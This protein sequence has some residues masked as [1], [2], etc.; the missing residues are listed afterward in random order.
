MRHL[1]WALVLGLLVTVPVS[2]QDGAETPQIDDLLGTAQQDGG[3]SF[4][5]EFEISAEL[6]AE[7]V[8]IGE[9]AY[10][11]IH[12]TLPMGHHISSQNPKANAPTKI[13]V[14]TLTG[15]EPIDDGFTPTETPDAHEDEFVGYVEYF[16]DKATW[17]RRY[18]ILDPSNAT[19]I[20]TLNG[21]YC[22][23][24]PGGQCTPVDNAE[25]EAKLDATL[26]QPQSVFNIQVTPTRGK[27]NKPDPVSLEFDLPEGAKVGDEITLR[28]TMILDEGW[29]AFS[30]DQNP[31]N[32]GLPIVLGVSGLAGLEAIDEDFAVDQT[33]EEV[34]PFD[35]GTIQLQLHDTV[36]WTQR[37]RVTDPVY[38]VRG[39]I[40]YQ[41]CRDNCLAPRDVE[42]HL[43]SLITT[44]AS[45]TPSRAASPDEPANLTMGLLFAFL[46]G[47][48]LNVMPCVLPVLSIKMLSFA[49]Q[50]GESRGRVLQLNLSYAVGVISVFLLLAGLA[51]AAGYG[52]GELFQQ[53]EFN[54]VMTVIIFVMA[55]SL[56]GVFEIPIPGLGGG[57]GFTEKE[58]PTGAFLTGILAT[59]LATPCSGPFLGP[60]LGWSIKQQAFETF[61]IWGVMGFGMAFPYVLV[62][63]FPAAIRFLPKPGMWMVRF[64]EICGFALLATV[65]YFVTLLEERYVVPLLIML[66]G[67]AVSLWMI[68]KLYQHNSPPKTKWRVRG[69]ALTSIAVVGSFSYWMSIEGLKLPWQPFTEQ[70][71]KSLMAEKKTIMV[72][73]SAEWCQTCKWNELYA[74][75]TEETLAVIEEHGIIPVYA[76]YTHRSPEIKKWLD[77]FD[78][79]SIPLTV[80]VP[81]GDLKRA[82]I[83]RDTFSKK[84]LLEALK[85][86]AN[87]NVAMPW[88]APSPATAKQF[89]D[90][91]ATALIHF[92]ADYDQST[93]LNRRT[94]ID[95]P[96]T[97]RFVEEH[98]I[99][100]LRIDCTDRTPECEEWTERFGGF[101][102]AM[103]MTVVVPKGDLDRATVLRDTFCKEE[104]LRVLRVAVTEET[105]LV[106]T[107]ARRDGDR[108][109]SVAWSD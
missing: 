30:R 12:V 61:L 50:A 25:F 24:G 16:H 63:M 90:D 35:D 78:S 47:L 95:V 93:E 67:I 38:A 99:I 104:L 4:G 73:F 87:A 80:I 3:F 77:H 66:L 37:Y 40:T 68:G 32:L 20:G 26:E 81:Q 18:K 65:I 31:D 69:M 108:V 21:L 106:R 13:G 28:V 54:L 41:V 55:L 59:V 49:K 86:A 5:G 91:K 6:V 94:A 10:L 89:V 51:I 2:A 23:S 101:W 19:A 17:V 8:A 53:A 11:K 71:F 64:K 46:G 92:A 34:D 45:V 29:H 44:L 57:G 96:E 88:R 15:L 76:D 9:T 70:R 27:K 58:G 33:P 48:I 84:R 103:P 36:N 109:G 85:E 39:A 1:S 75:N 100:P 56:L 42:F 102:A 97:V 22:E 107:A 98:G 79:I 105:P 7:K 14:H 74:L 72:D 60:V 62:G 82:I 43:G 52:W 83:L